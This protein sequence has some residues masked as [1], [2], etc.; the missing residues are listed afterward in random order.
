M[1]YAWEWLACRA[2]DL[3]MLDTRAHADYFVSRFKIDDKRTSSVLVGAELNFF[4]REQ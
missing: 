4:G 2:A 3:V 1:L